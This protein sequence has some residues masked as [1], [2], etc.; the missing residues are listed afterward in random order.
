MNGDVMLSPSEIEA[1]FPSS[2]GLV[3]VPGFSV[4]SRVDGQPVQVTFFNH[5]LEVVRDRLRVLSAIPGMEAPLGVVDLSEKYGIF[6]VVEGSEQKK[7]LSSDAVDPI[8][9]RLSVLQIAR[10][11]VLADVR[12]L[13]TPEDF[14]RAGKL[15][16]RWVA[17]PLA[18]ADSSYAL[19]LAEL[20]CRLPRTMSDTGTGSGGGPAVDFVVRHLSEILLRMQDLPDLLRTCIAFLD[21]FD[22][23]ASSAISRDPI[24]LKRYVVIVK[25][26]LLGSRVSDDKRWLKEQN[27]PLSRMVAFVV[28]DAATVDGL[29][30]ED[31]LAVASSCFFS[32]S[33][34]CQFVLATYLVKT[35]DLDSDLISIPL[36]STSMLYA[37]AMEGDLFSQFFL[38][39]S[40]GPDSA[41]EL[42]LV[43][44]SFAS[45]CISS[46][47][48]VMALEHDF[49][50][51][52]LEIRHRRKMLSELQNSESAAVSSSHLPSMNSEISDTDLLLL[53]DPSQ[54][55]MVSFCLNE[56]SE[57]EMRLGT[58]YHEALYDKL[59]E[60]I[61]SGDYLEARLTARVLVLLSFLRDS[62]G[63]YCP[64]DPASNVCCLFEDPFSSLQSRVE[65]SLQ[66]LSALPGDGGAGAVSPRSGPSSSVSTFRAA[67]FLLRNGYAGHELM[68]VLQDSSHMCPP[69][70]IVSL[71]RRWSRPSCSLD[72]LVP[73]GELLTSLETEASRLQR[74]G[75]VFVMFSLQ[76]RRSGDAA[77]AVRHGRSLLDRFPLQVAQF[78][79]DV[80]VSDRSLFESFERPIALWIGD[81][82]RKIVCDE[83]RFF[84]VLQQSERK[85]EVWA[86]FVHVAQM[87]PDAEHEAELLVLSCLAPHM[88]ETCV[89]N[90]HEAVQEFLTSHPEGEEIMDRILGEVCERARSSGF[91]SRYSNVLI[92]AGMRSLDR[93]DNSDA[94][95]R[96]T[97]GMLLGSAARWHKNGVAYS[98]L[99]T[100]LADSSMHPVA[101]AVMG[102]LSTRTLPRNLQRLQIEFGMAEAGDPEDKAN[103]RSELQFSLKTARK[104]TAG[105]KQAAGGGGCCIS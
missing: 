47:L 38:G 44:W 8:A 70:V 84:L 102:E 88:P 11:L 87:Q 48:L 96:L 7:Q 73:S 56:A 60:Y 9:L 76:R 17:R 26:N 71:M 65:G 66:V 32:G 103:I 28:F 68:E 33:A 77:A 101:L 54:R 37:A 104:S 83:K 82:L 46:A 63:T 62:V 52:R 42:S 85:D 105:G 10:N 61:S 92:L 72:T 3:V 14:D 49:I 98:L 13:V 53:Q 55:R 59:Q 50:T 91:K 22:P 23:K 69:E 89:V 35:M 31:V 30:F 58:K 36:C 15:R 79:S 19:H 64:T 4:S 67:C 80:L 25:D 43:D 20:M 5:S 1:N 6:G 97:R 78:F 29:E 95:I 100:L 16:S 74:L 57:F 34:E 99:K 94:V 41:A 24:L 93:G 45:F 75:A 39:N 81:E 40:L 90:V 2:Q 18:D 21:K 12:P 51:A 86:F 27:N